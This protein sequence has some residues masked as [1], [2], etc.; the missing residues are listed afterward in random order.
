MDR[1]IQFGTLV[2]NINRYIQKLKNMEMQELGLKGNQVQ[3]IYHL[4]KNK[5]GL[6]PKQLSVI[7]DEDKAA[8]SRTLK[9]LDAK[10]LVF[11]NK[12]DE[13]SY[14]NPYKLTKE[15]LKDGEYILGKIDSFVAIASNGIDAND[16]AVLYKS[17]TTICN[18]LEKVFIDKGEKND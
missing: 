3:C 7:C 18:N 15:G 13:K 2:Q 4:Y 14:G 8:I 9:D 16:R 6:N 17:L 1:Y 11:V 10:G 12:I 5:C